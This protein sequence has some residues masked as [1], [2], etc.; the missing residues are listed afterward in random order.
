MVCLQARPCI[1]E[2]GILQVV[3]VKGLSTTGS[4]RAV[5]CRSLE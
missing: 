2:P 5:K 3:E 4:D 1:F